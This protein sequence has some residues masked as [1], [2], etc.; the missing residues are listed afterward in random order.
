MTNIKVLFHIKL[1]LRIRKIT[2]QKIC[3]DNKFLF[4]HAHLKRFI[5][6]FISLFL[7]KNKLIK[8]IINTI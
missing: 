2:F 3:L 5:I 7:I 4:V 1:Q 8:L 6:Y